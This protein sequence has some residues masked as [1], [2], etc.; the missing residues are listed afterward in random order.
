MQGHSLQRNEMKIG[1]DNTIYIEKQAQAISERINRFDK[2]YLEFGGKLFDDLHAA[3]VLPGFDP[4]VKT[5]MLLTLKDKLEVIFCISA[6]SLEENK[7]RADFGITYDADLLRLVSNLREIGIYVS[8]IVITQ[9]SGQR[10]ADLF[11]TK[12][13]R[14]GEKVYVHYLTKGYPNDVNTIVSDEGFGANTYIETTR[15]LVVVT[16]PGPAS[17]KLATCLSQLY[18]EYKRGNKAGY[19]KYESFPVWNL[20]LSHPLN[21]AYEAATA[22]LQDCNMIDP[23]H[24]EAYNMSTVN[25]NRDV[26]IFPVVK[27]ILNRILGE[28]I[29]K[30]PTDM[31]VN[32]IGFAIS[33][34]EVVCNASKQEI[35]RRYYQALC[36]YKQGRTSKETVSRIEMLMTKLGLS[37]TERKVVAS[38]LK[39][40]EE[41][42]CPAC[43]LE[44]PDGSIVRSRN[45]DALDAAAAIVIN[46]MKKYVDVSKRLPLIAPGLIKPI[47]KVK[48]DVLGE[49]KTALDLG[50]VLIAL[51]VSIP[52]NTTIEEIM[53]NIHILNGCEAHSTV[54]LDESEMQTLRKLGIRM[55]CEPEYDA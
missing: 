36:D 10:S 7:R 24:L 21:V 38:A 42:G 3:R 51:S 20:P 16:A 2:L 40:Q 11:R 41:R 52:T 46:A 23:F 25:Y 26:A 18:H 1:F 39:K 37:T 27:N 47:T 30:S 48:R 55:T 9:Y 12:L 28:D 31:G 32:M 43:A 19:A 54:M 14:M 33:N 17:G 34:D 44:L 5:K 35:I 15:P 22:D 8:S 50:E 13:E 6:P 45:T 29:Y 49:K 4:N 53:N